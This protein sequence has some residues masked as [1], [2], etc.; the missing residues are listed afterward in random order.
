MALGEEIVKRYLVML[1]EN[2]DDGI[3][4]HHQN[5]SSVV[6]GSQAEAGKKFL[7]FNWPFLINGEEKIDLLVWDISVQP[8]TIRYRIEYSPE[9]FSMGEV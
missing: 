1:E 2:F 5:W 3:D 4:K 7:E 9:F 6:A 8:V